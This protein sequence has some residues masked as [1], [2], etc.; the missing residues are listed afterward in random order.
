MA[1][2]RGVDQ[3]EFL[4]I[5]LRLGAGQLQ[6]ILVIAKQNFRFMTLADVLFIN[7]KVV[8]GMK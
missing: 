4:R 2:C 6:K 5:Y 7:N 3:E 1:A 8:G